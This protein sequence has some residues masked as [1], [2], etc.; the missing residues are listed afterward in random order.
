MKVKPVYLV[1]LAV[2]AVTVY[3]LWKGQRPDQAPAR[4][5]RPSPQ[6][7]PGYGVYAPAPGNPGGGGVVQQLGG[8]KGIAQGAAILGGL[9]FDIWDRIAA[10]NDSP[11]PDEL[12]L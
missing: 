10:G 12:A 5:G 8:A 2:A 3:V 1:V 9:A 6:A 4:P 7:P 11:P